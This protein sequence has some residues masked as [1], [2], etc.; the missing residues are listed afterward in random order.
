VVNL[1]K[2]FSWANFTTDSS[3]YVFCALSFT[4]HG[5]KLKNGNKHISY[6]TMRDLFQKVIAPHVTDIT[7]YCLHSLRSGGATAA[8]N[9]GV[10]DRIFKRHGRLV[11]EQAKD[12]YVKDNLEERLL[13]S[14]CLGL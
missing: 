5:Y 8:A 9:K 12:G 7:K 1:E 14:R 10:K 2:Y 11:S 3:F 13:V 4:K 6:S